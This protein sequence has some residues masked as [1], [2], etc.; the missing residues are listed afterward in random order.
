MQKIGITCIFNIIL[1]SC[2]DSFCNVV[3]IIQFCFLYLSSIVEKT[4]L[5]NE[6]IV[7]IT[8]FIYIIIFFAI[9]LDE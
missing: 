4:G 1:Y 8:F 3:L 2:C 7:A 5:V 9:I 6:N